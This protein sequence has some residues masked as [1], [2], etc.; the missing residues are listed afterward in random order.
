MNTCLLCNQ[1]YAKGSNIKFHKR[2]I[3]NLNRA[4][5]FNHYIQVKVCRSCFNKYQNLIL[6][7]LEPYFG[8]N[9]HPEYK[10]HRINYKDDSLML[11]VELELEINNLSLFKE[12]VIYSISQE[13]DKIN[14]RNLVYLKHDGSLKYGIEIVTQPMTLKFLINRFNVKS[15]LDSL[16]K[17]FTVLS[18]CGMHIHVDKKFIPIDIFIAINQFLFNNRLLMFIFSGRGKYIDLNMQ[19]NNFLVNN[20]YYSFR[21]ASG[22]DTSR[23][24]D[25]GKYFSLAYRENTAEFR[26]FA[27]TLNY[28]IYMTNIMFIEAIIRYIE[29]YNIKRVML[30]NF[31]KF[32]KEEGY[33]LLLERII[34]AKNKMPKE[35]YGK[36]LVLT[37]NQ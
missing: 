7:N 8:H 22:I 31:E 32:L 4:E 16:Q 25:R 23:I 10:Y 1:Q 21:S 9:E 34:K 5:T 37:P 24:L 19:R 29:V 14:A 2:P 20:R 17:Y 18:T 26:F 30:S 15:L 13:L 3:D 27:S 12:Q 28:D 11:G 6:Q 35:N 33:S 36:A